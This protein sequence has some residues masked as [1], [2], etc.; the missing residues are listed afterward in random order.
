MKNTKQ[1]GNVKTGRGTSLDDILSK[2][3]KK[4][5]K[6]ETI[7]LGEVLSK[8]NE[9]PEIVVDYLKNSGQ[10]SFIAGR[11]G[12]P[13][14]FVFGDV[15]DK[16]EHSEFIRAQWRIRNGRNPETGTLLKKPSSQVRPRGNIQVTIGAKTVSIPLK[17]AL[18][19]Q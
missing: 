17:L 15:K 7:E 19:N 2:L 5:G 6:D 9:S 8:T 4:H 3:M 13:S 11:R 12:H 16:W 14:R 10:G 18:A 1:I